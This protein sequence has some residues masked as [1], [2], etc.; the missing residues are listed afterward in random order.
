MEQLKQFWEIKSNEERRKIIVYSIA[1]LLAVFLLVGVYV[2]NGGDK[3]VAVDEI[4]NPD[5]KEAQKYNSRTEA[6]QL[7]KKDSSKLNTAMDDLFGKSGDSPIEI[8]SESDGN[9]KPTSTY[10]E[11]VYTQ[12]NYNNSRSEKRNRGSSYNSHSTYGD[13]SMWQAEEPKNNSIAYTE[14]KNYPKSSRSKN[15]NA[16]SNIDYTEIFEPAYVQP[17]Y[18]GSSTN[19]RSINEGKQIRAKLLSKGYANSGRTLSFV[20]LESTKIGTLET[21]K[22]QIIKGVASEQNNRLLVNFSTIKVKNKI[23]PV[24]LQLYGADGMA[25]LP[26]SPGTQNSDL[27]NRALNESSRIPVIGG[28]INSVGNAMSKQ[29]DKRIKLTFNVECIIVNFN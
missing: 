3:K 16:S 1:S 22:G 21:P 7:G 11:P 9:D 4:S 13:Y 12:P 27:E 14:V 17:S 5:A 15:E 29:S 6:N 20:L 8:I 18:S 24:Q 23:V 26:I 28:V 25:G 2:L 10:V 19:Q